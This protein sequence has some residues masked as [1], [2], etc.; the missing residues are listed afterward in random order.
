MRLFWLV[1]CALASFGCKRHED[2]PRPVPSEAVPSGEPS[3]A[4]IVAS[5]C[6]ARKPCEL[7][8]IK[9]AGPELLVVSLTTDPERARDAAPP[10]DPEHCV[11]YEHWLLRT[12]GQ[13]IAERR[14]LLRL[15]NDG[16]GASGVGEDTVTVAPNLF[17]HRQYGGSAWRWENTRVLE[18][19]PLRVKTTAWWSGATIAPVS[20]RGTFDWS[21]FRGRVRWYKPPC[22]AGGGPP[23]T[24]DDPGIGELDN[25][26]RALT[27][28]PIPVVSIAKS[29]D[30][31]T[32][33]LGSCAPV[34]DGIGERGFVTHGPPGDANDASM[35]VV[36][37]EAGASIVLYVEIKDD[38]ILG[39][40]AK[41]LFDDHLELWLKD[42]DPDPSELCVPG[43]AG[44]GAGKLRQWAIRVA[45]GALFPGA[46]AKSD[47]ITVER[48]G[49]RFKITIASATI[50]S[51]TVVYS[52][53]DDGKT[54]ERLIATS[55]LKFNVSATLGRL[56]PIS[57][58]EAVCEV[59][60]GRLEHKPT[61]AFP[62][63]RPILE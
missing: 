62:A 6:G 30:F 11:P 23:L 50:E 54:Q 26:P 17:T 49:T 22:P 63:D 10:F 51:L 37:A 42:E 20:E 57:R 27:Y 7:L 28:D 38:A 34:I 39:P 2:A 8:E 40:S 1:L 43:G 14:E 48:E 36:A 16:Y 5:V 45:D 32:T 15:C 13:A 58:E 55:Q 3:R 24:G 9:K 47:P 31:K 4:Q 12:R 61:R 19:S 21:E 52:D 18:L 35:R 53:S 59:V 46:H 41:W 44:G 29:F 60:G 25:D 56:R 33:P